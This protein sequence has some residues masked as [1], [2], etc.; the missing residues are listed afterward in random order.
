MGYAL[1]NNGTIRRDRRFS[2]GKGL[3]VVGELS[4]FVCN[5]AMWF[6]VLTS[7]LNRSRFP[8]CNKSAVLDPWGACRFCP[9]RPC[10]QTAFYGYPMGF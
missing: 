6:W 8:P 7:H 10:L 4:F 5:Q 2:G 1:R 3:D 9:T